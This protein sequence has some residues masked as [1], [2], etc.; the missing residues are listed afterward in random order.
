M[1][2]VKGILKW[3]WGHKLA[4]FGIV[5][6][7]GFIVLVSVAS[8]YS[9]KKEAEANEEVAEED[10]GETDFQTE[11]KE[12]QAKYVDKFG[13]PNEGF[14]WGDDGQQIAYGTEAKTPEDVAFVYLRSLS[15]LDFA[16]AQ[17]YSFKTDTVTTYQNFFIQ[18]PEF[19]YNSDFYQEV[20]KQ[21]LLSMQPM[22]VTD[23]SSFADFREVVTVEIEIIDL[24]D[25]DFWKPEKIPLFEELRK[26]RITERDTTKV[27]DF[28][29][30]YVSSYYGSTNPKTTKTTVSLVLEQTKDD[31]W[32]VTNDS[33]LDAYAQYQDGELVASDIMENFNT[34][35]GEQDMSSS[36]IAEIDENREGDTDELLDFDEGK[37]DNRSSTDY[38]NTAG[39]NL[40]DDLGSEDFSEF[41][42]YD[43]SGDEIPPLDGYEDEDKGEEQE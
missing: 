26:Y 43:Y 15:T 37:K 5:V 42:D 29:Y 18:D 38:N 20:Y 14:Y 2:I 3:F 24:M 19:S 39:S 25:K 16:N 22:R 17:R 4:T 13:E 23:V 31:T 10:V 40:Y 11:F 35:L 12:E 27:R 6:I 28:I 30:R 41:D 34:W 32:L 33:D 8:N 1:A 9:A 7:L 21:A 36:E